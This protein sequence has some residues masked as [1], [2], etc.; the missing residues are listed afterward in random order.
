MT[1]RRRFRATGKRCNACLTDCETNPRQDRQTPTW[2]ANSIPLL[3]RADG[4]PA[5]TPDDTGGI[6]EVTIEVWKN[7]TL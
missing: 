7:E 6:A 3:E 5:M 1:R 2:Q 4:Q